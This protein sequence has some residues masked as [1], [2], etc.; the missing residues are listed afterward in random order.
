[1]ARVFISHR[2]VEEDLVLARALRDGLASAGHGSFLAGD[3]LSIGDSWP[4]R[5]AEELAGADVLLLLLSPEAAQSEMVIEEVRQARELRRRGGRPRILPVRVREPA[6]APLPYDLGAYLGRLQQVAWL[7]EE[8]TPA[9][10]SELLRVVDAGIEGV[11]F[12]HHPGEAQAPAQGEQ[13]HGAG[14]TGPL[15]RG[16]AD[17]SAEDEATLTPQPATQ[18]PST[19]PA[20]PLQP[21]GAPYTG[22][23][24]IPH[25][26]AEKEARTYLGL[27]GS[28]VVLVGPYQSGKSWMLH[29]ILTGC[30]EDGDLVVHLTLDHLPDECLDS[31]DALLME[32]AVEL[33][34]AAGLDED[35]ISRAWQLPAHPLRKLSRM[36]E[37]RILPSIQGR[38]LL[39]LDRADTVL[40]HGYHNDF[41]G[42]LRSWAQ[43]AA[44]PPWDRF[45]LL[46]AISTEPSLLVSSA[47]LSPFNLSPPIRLG[48][49]TAEQ[50]IAL[51]QRHG[52]PWGSDDVSLLMSVIGGHPYLVRLTLFQAAHNDIPLPQLL[53]EATSEGGLYAD[54][55]R[56][57]LL[58]LRANPELADAVRR[59]MANAEAPV[60]YLVADRLI[61]AGIVS[62][63]RG[64]YDLR[65]PLYRTFLTGRL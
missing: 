46:A 19:E 58:R 34:D 42:M 17:L 23:W 30:S 44:R 50:V 53:A 20:A 14:A 24:Y 60:D 11:P 26:R 54:H 25:D 9:L 64:R 31:L 55:L 37:R 15:Y 45:R 12:G 32:V 39:A 21:P 5:I 49:F 41:F 48:D 47:N 16:D 51:A 4:E 13:G 8:H 35:A 22:A 27:P 36:V 61:S 65:Y 6:G 2:A 57:R 18:P 1:M 59:L 3:S 52:L 10:L 29:H 38:L 40:A 28:P 43:G 62:G 33:C 63:H 7:S 56:S